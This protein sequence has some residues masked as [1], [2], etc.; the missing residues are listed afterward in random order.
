MP[1]AEH[2]WPGEISSGHFGGG[3]VAIT[4]VRPALVIEIAADPALQAGRHRHAVRLLR[5]RPDLSPTDISTDS[6]D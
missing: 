3:P 4:H 5:L 2:P 6:T 1:A